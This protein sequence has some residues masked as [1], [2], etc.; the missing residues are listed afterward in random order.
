MFERKKTS[1]GLKML[2]QYARR[3][4]IL[5]RIIVAPQD[6]LKQSIWVLKEE[7]REVRLPSRQLKGSERKY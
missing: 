4:I 5:I 7:K 1:Y 2:Q 3:R 6:T